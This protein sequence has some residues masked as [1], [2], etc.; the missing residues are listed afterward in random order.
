MAQPP[1]GTVTFLF[2]DIEGST[3]LV[4]DLGS[5]WRSVLEKHQRLLR[6]AFAAHH[7]IERGTEGDSFLVVFTHASEA[8][9][10]AIDA[11]QAL[12]AAN[13][14]TGLHLRVRMGLHSGDARRG[15]DDYIGLDIHRAARIAAAAHGGQI[16][17]SDSTRSLVERE[18]SPSIV[19][20]DLGEHRLK[21]LDWPE[22]LYQLDIPGRRNDFPPIR[23]VATAGYLPT[24]TTSFVGRSREIEDVVDLLA[25]Q[26]LVTLTGP[27]GVG[28]TRLSLRVAHAVADDFVDGAWFVSL[29]TV[30]DADQMHSAVAAALGVH[31]RSGGSPGGAVREYARTRVLLLILDNL[32]QV[33]GAHEVVG[34]LL[35]EAPKL[36]ILATSRAPLHVGGEQEYPVASLLA[37]D[38]SAP[39]GPD[40]LRGSDA[41]SL[42]VERAR[43]VRPGLAIDDE[44]L[45][46]IAEIARRVDGLPLAIELAAARSRLFS[47]DQVLRGLGRRL[48]SLV[49]GPRDAPERQRSMRGAFAWSHD[50]LTA[51]EQ[52]VF[53]RLGVFVG[54]WDVDAADA[55]VRAV[56]PATNAVDEI[57]G[58]VEQSLVRPVDSPAEP[59]FVMLDT[60]REYALERLDR[61]GESERAR[62]AHAAHFAALAEQVGSLLRTPEAG[63]TLDR[64]ERDIGNLRGA[65]AW[66]LESGDVDTG[67]RLAAALG[68]FWHQRGHMAEARSAIVDL[69]DQPA[70]ADSQA[71]ANAIMTA[72]SLANWQGDY[73]T[74]RRYGERALAMLRESGDQAAIAAELAEL[75]Y[76]T[77]LDDPT[78]ATR[79]I[80][81][82]VAIFESLGDETG[83]AR[84]RLGLAAAQ[85]GLG[86]LVAARDSVERSLKHFREIGDR[87]YPPFALTLLGR[88]EMVG[89]DLGAAER[90]F[91]DGINNAVIA[92]ST[93]GLSVN[94]WALASVAIERGDAARG[95]RLAGRAA[96]LMEDVGGSM[97]G[98]VAGTTDV[99]A[100]ARS[101]LG[102]ADYEQ[103]VSDGLGASIDAVIAEA[104]TG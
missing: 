50:L 53:R 79:M 11:E 81:E 34:E 21:D 91:R 36:R 96:R 83:A 18:L 70:A 98:P 62:R 37:P 26:R 93:I 16:L 45:R 76:A 59:R 35:A 13:W 92:R 56:D 88:I 77:I 41:V 6:R 85:L 32:E 69:L 42:F 90:S 66:S 10:A 95:A 73:S 22:R 89:G 82:C 86:E 48:D 75:G 57:Q 63:T 51:R 46:D 68:G 61:A 103:A 33:S 104:L 29:S 102:T 12:D 71:A 43:L 7:G 52:A 97:R 84:A 8:V 30:S 14:P 44:V 24:E 27:G 60:I 1:T 5:H 65:L 64:L 25:A 49:G 58:L 20:R 9:A 80:E 87:Y 17:L 39:A 78:E 40:A 72:G 38:P 4:Q 67:L 47:P 74:G 99:L 19:I 101:E 23:A 15:G 54:E 31:S 2:T 3:R 94:L 55:V 100:R 28:K